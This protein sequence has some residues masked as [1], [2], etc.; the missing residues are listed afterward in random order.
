MEKVKFGVPLDQVCDE[1]KDIP[2]PLLMLIL[3][4]N[5]EAPAKKDV[6]RA[7]G[8]QANVKKLIHVLQVSIT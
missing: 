4:L 6:F 7:P 8:H 3:K 5:K 1:H 2:A